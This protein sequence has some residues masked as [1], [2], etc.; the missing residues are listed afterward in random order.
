[1]SEYVNA[2]ARPRTKV[3][4]DIVAHVDDVGR[5][6]AEEASEFVE[7]AASVHLRRHHH[8]RGAHS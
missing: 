7:A 8:M 4:V 5:R 3:A 6:A 2:R 1:M